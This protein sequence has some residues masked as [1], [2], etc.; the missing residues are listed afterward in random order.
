MSDSSTYNIQDPQT[1]LLAKVAAVELYDRLAQ[2][3]P[4]H[5]AEAFRQLQADKRRQVLEIRDKYS[6]KQMPVTKSY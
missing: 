6:M 4:T 1:R 3:S 2:T 5:Q